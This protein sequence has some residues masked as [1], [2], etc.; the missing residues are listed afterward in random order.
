MYIQEIRLGRLWPRFRFIETDSNV[1]LGLKAVW[2]AVRFL[3][4]GLIRRRA[5]GWMSSSDSNLDVTQTEG[6][7]L[8]DYQRNHVASLASRF[9]GERAR[10]LAFACNYPSPQV[11]PKPH[12]EGIQPPDKN[13]RR[14]INQSKWL[15][16]RPLTPVAG[17]P[18]S[19][20]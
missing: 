3:V 2:R 19:G 14:S 5:R 10:V 4:S 9:K 6:T 7:D 16:T 18:Y 1:L 20:V 8:L 17:S 11:H 15:Q 13:S 12:P